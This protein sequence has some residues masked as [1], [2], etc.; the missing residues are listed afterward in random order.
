MKIGVLGSSGGGVFTAVEELFREVRPGAISW[1]VACDRPCGLEDRARELDLPRVRIGG[2][3][4]A[5]SRAAAEF[6]VAQDVTAVLLYYVRLVTGELFDRLATVNFHPAVLPAFP[7]L[8]ALERTV[9]A[10][11]H[12]F[13]A[14]THMVDATIDGGPI[15]AQVR[16]AVPVA[17]FETIAHISFVQKTYLTLL[18]LD[19]LTRGTLVIA[20]NAVPRWLDG[21]RLTQDLA[22]A[23]EAFAD[24]EGA[25]VPS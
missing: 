13:G 8:N 5:A 17:D 15:I 14:T 3:K 18:V 16:A 12:E 22:A 19:A 2:T 25:A 21:P 9:A 11:A 6:F 24:R 10:G 7:G 20:P 23:Y 4:A 1:S